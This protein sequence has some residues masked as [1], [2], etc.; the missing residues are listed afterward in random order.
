MSNY[1]DELI[2]VAAVALAMVQCDLN[3]DSE[4]DDIGAA[5]LT[6]LLTEVVA[7]RK[8]QEAKFGTRVDEPGAD[9]LWYVVLGEEFGEVGRAI[10][11]RQRP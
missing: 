11:E 3:G 2:Q 9:A 6:G 1:T 10:L 4:L 8:R 7:E 5:T